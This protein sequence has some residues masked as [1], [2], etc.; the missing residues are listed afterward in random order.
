MV[1]HKEHTK[2]TQETFQGPV[3]KGSHSIWQASAS[4]DVNSSK[5]FFPKFFLFPAKEQDWE[6]V[7]SLLLKILK[8]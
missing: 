3:P 1:V 2:I 4:R 5:T 6:Y 8:N 7:L